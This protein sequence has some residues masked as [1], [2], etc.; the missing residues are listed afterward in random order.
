[1][2]AN[3]A[4]GWVMTPSE[5]QEGTCVPANISRAGDMWRVAVTAVDAHG[6][7]SVQPWVEYF[8]VVAN[9]GGPNDIIGWDY[10]D[11][12]STGYYLTGTEL[13]SGPANAIHEMNLAWL[14]G[15]VTAETAPNIPDNDIGDDGVVFLNAPWQPCETVCVDVRVSAGSA[16]TPDV[17]LY[18]YA[19][20]DGNL[21]FDF[22]DQLCDGAA[23]ECLIGGAPILGLRA[24]HDSLYHFCFPD[25]GVTDIGRYR[26]VLRFRLLSEPAGCGG[27]LTMI[28]PRLGET[29]DYVL[30]DLQLAVELQSFTAAQDGE[31]VALA[32]AT[33]SETDN[34][35]FAVERQTAGQGW[36]RIAAHIAAAGTAAN[37]QHYQ[38]RDELVEPGR[39]YSYRL[40]AVTTA[41]TAQVIATRDVAVQAAPAVIQEYRLYPN[42]PNPFNPTTTIAF[43]LRD[44]GQVS[45]L[46]YDVMGREVATLVNAPLAAGRHQVTFEARNL[47][48]GVYLYRLTTAGYT[49]LHKM[50]LLK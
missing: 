18:L 19:W 22:N 24:S 5:G 9:C 1:M 8:V 23:P 17:P 30:R 2:V 10:G 49:E 27:G 12:D 39:V 43:D 35:H 36:E 29:E 47:P 15:T 50:I 4:S 33:A 7:A 11:L 32:W 21:D 16:Y 3:A 13:S 38:F 37:T 28:D 45:L 20:K 14:G 42:Y 44:A 6:E 40:I 46:V 41:G 25:P 26:G 31:A 48:S 34:D